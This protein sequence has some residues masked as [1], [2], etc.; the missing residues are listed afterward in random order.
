MAVRTKMMGMRLPLRLD[1]K[2][3]DY[4]AEHDLT[5]TEAMTAVLERGLEAINGS[6]NS[7]TNCV[8][9]QEQIDRLSDDLN[10]LTELVND[11]IVKADR[12][13]ATPKPKRK[14]R[15]VAEPEDDYEGDIHWGETEK[16]VELVPEYTEPETVSVGL[17]D[18]EFGK[19][20]GLS[21]YSLEHCK[22]SPKYSQHKELIAGHYFDRQSC[23]W[24]SPT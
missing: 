11:Y 6:D 21:L 3:E 16:Q 10:K 19:L 5:F 7:E 4:R 12:A 23:M 8:D 17:S 1:E 20:T 18:D 15:V 9:Y 14:S 24:K 22:S 13:V 2:I